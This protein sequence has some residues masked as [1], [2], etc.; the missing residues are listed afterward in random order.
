M[1]DEAGYRE[2]MLRGDQ[3]R[4]ERE[5]GE[6]LGGMEFSPGDW[7]ENGI[8]ESWFNRVESKVEMRRSFWDTM[9]WNGQEWHFSTVFPLESG[10]P[11]ESLWTRF[12][13]VI[14]SRTG[15]R[16]K[17]GTRISSFFPPDIAASLKQ[18]EIGKANPVPGSDGY[19]KM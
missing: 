7:A 14:A 2:E 8:D 15:M 11:T 1:T 17:T 12:S 5:S 9:E 4:K 10:H 18:L 6:T 19:L 16:M 13:G 3:Q